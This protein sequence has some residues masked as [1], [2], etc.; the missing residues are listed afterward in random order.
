MEEKGNTFITGIIQSG[1]NHSGIIEPD[2]T[3]KNT[4]F[5]VIRLHILISQNEN[6]WSKKLKFHNTP[7]PRIALAINSKNLAKPAGGKTPTV[8]TQTSSDGR[9]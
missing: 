2:N 9:K 8:N 4:F 1:I 6:A 3:F 5:I 7:Y